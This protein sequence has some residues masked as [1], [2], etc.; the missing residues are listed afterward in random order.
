LTPADLSFTLRLKNMVFWSAAWVT[1]SGAHGIVGMGMGVCCLSPAGRARSAHQMQAAVRQ[2]M[3]AA[4][5]GT[6]RVLVIWPSL[7]PIL[8][9]AKHRLARDACHA[10]Q[11][12]PPPPPATAPRAR[13]AARWGAQPACPAP[14]GAH[15]GRGTSC[16][17]QW[18]QPAACPA[19]RA[20]VGRS[21][22]CPRRTTGSSAQAAGHRPRARLQTPAAGRR[23]CSQRERAGAVEVARGRSS[24]CHL[25]RGGDAVVAACGVGWGGRTCPRQ[26]PG[27]RWQTA[28]SSSWA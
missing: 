18:A 9:A 22:C 19:P 12:P 28:C 6:C 5:S 4:V 7:A 1:C 3:R 2:A 8:P 24:I 14:T 21:A 10:Q 11:P 26:R 27:C 20:T 16:A 15:L 17:P 25:T 13:L 23:S